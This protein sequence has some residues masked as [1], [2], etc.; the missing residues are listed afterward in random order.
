MSASTAILQNNAA[1][2]V[3]SMK[4]SIPNPTRE[5]LP[6]IAPTTMATRP[7]RVFQAIVK[8]SRFRPRREIAARVITLLSAMLIDYHVDFRA[9]ELECLYP[10]WDSAAESR[11][12]RFSETGFLTDSHIPIIYF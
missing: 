5:M 4:L 8:Y 12:V 9:K 6:A 3:T 1:P 10:A 2:D 7:S 11:E